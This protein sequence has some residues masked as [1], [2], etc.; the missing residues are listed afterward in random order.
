MLVTIFANGHFSKSYS[1]SLSVD[2]SD[3]VIAADGGAHHCELLGILPD[4]LI[5]DSDSISSELLYKYQ[6]NKVEIEKFPVDKDATDLELS[7]DFAKTKY[8]DKINIF[9]CLGGRWDMSLANI[10]L[11]CQAKYEEIEITLFADDCRI[12]LLAPGTHKLKGAIGQT[13]SLLPINGNGG[14]LTLSG[15]KYSLTSAQIDFGSSL[16]VSNII[17]TDNPQVSFKSGKLLL[18]YLDK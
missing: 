7:I 3:I 9:G 17:T 11:L 15:L 12:Q 4:I 6:E 5:G 18:V 1:A 10:F 16:G 13:I 8:A 2:K 14:E